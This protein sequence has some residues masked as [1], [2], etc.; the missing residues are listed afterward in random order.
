MESQQFNK[1]FLPIKDL[2]CFKYAYATE[3]FL[4]KQNVGLISTL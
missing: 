3:E 1:I 2:A 4:D